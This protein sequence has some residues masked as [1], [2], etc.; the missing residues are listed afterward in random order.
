MVAL[1]NNN[2]DAISCIVIM[3]DS[4]ARENDSAVEVETFHK[5]DCEIFNL[6]TKGS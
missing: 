1:E 6:I 4:L 2:G 3:V 5:E